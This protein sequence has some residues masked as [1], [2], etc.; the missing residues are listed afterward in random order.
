MLVVAIKSN[1]TEVFADTDE[2]EESDPD[3]LRIDHREGIRADQLLIIPE[4]D[5]SNSITRDEWAELMEAHSDINYDGG[6]DE[7]LE[8]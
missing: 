6:I 7:E 2:I 8:E 1:H 5:V 4:E 3:W